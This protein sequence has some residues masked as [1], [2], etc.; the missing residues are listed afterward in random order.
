MLIIQLIYFLKNHLN[1]LQ[2]IEI[3]NIVI[4]VIY[5][6][7]MYEKQHK[8]HFYYNLYSGKISLDDRQMA[9]LKK[10]TINTKTTN[11]TTSQS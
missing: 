9:T 6:C 3:N 7:K 2:F 10:Y 11:R 8:T 1:L 5:E 4:S